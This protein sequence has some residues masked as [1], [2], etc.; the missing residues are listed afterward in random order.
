MKFESY[1]LD[2]E[3]YDRVGF[4][5]EPE[6]AEMALAYTLDVSLQVAYALQEAHQQENLPFAQ[7]A[8]LLKLI[9]HYDQAHSWEK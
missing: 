7:A 2:G 9:A 8:Q 5:Y 4:A 6:S 3:T 1:I